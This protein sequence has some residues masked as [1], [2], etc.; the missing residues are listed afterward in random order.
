M[1]ADGVDAHN[2]GHVE[3][4]N[5]IREHVTDASGRCWCE[6]T[7]EAVGS[8]RVVVIHNA[9]D[10]REKAESREFAALPKSV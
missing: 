3:P 10:G 6:P 2:I 7:V 5:D 9:A 8:G 4:I 1:I